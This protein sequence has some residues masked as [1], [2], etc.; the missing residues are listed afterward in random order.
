MVA[1]A[2]EGVL[3]LSVN[4][5]NINET[6]SFSNESNLLIINEKVS[7]ATTLALLVGIFQVNFNN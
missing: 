4:V 7:I 6:L 1:Q 3:G 2:I 5:S